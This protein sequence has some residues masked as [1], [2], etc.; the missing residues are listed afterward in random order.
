MGYIMRDDKN[1]SEY[2]DNAKNDQPDPNDCVAGFH[3]IM[4]EH[5]SEIYTLS[6]G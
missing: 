1:R 6:R 2:D 3:C 5:S 4:I